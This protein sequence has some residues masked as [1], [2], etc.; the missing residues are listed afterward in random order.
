VSARRR[1][2]GA[3]SL[4]C[5]AVSLAAP[6]GAGAQPGAL[7]FGPC[8]PKQVIS[9]PAGLQCA[10]L[11]V[12][13]DRANPAAG[14]IGLAVQRVP[15]SGP[16][17]GV[18]VLL[19]GGPGQPALPAFEQVVAPLAREHTL[20]GF[21]LVAFDQR[22]T[23]QSQSL[24]CPPEG[25]SADLGLPSPLGRGLSSYLNSCGAALGPTR[26]Y[27]TSQ[28]SVEDLNA[29]REALGGT[30]LSLFAV[31]YGTRVAGM[32]AREYPQGVARMVLDS[33]VPTTGPSP[34]GTERLHALHRVLDEG[35]CGGGACRAFS[36]DVYADLT[37]VVS[38]LHRHPLHTKT[39]NNRGRLRQATIT[40]KSLLS[41]LLGLDLAPLTRVL[42]PAAIAAAAHGHLAPLARIAG[43]MELELGGGGRAA[44]RAVP[45]P[46]SRF[47]PLEG[48]AGAGGHPS[49]ADVSTSAVLDVATSCVEDAL[50]WSP[51]SPPGARA[52]VLRRWLA[53]LPAGT[54]A[55]FSSAAALGESD[56]PLCEGWPA[57]TPAPPSPTGLSATPTL[58]LS[59][60][61]DLRTPY[62][63]VLAN[64]P[65]YSDA[66]LLRVPDDGHSTVT[67]DPTGCAKRA[68]IE[69]L[70]SGRA[71][72]SCPDSSEPQA[73]PLPPGSLAQV[74]PAASRSRLAGRIAAAAAITLEDLLGQDSFAG[75][76]LRGG[77]WELGELG[78]EASGNTFVLH[79]MV[80]VPGV[81][82]S[83]SVHLGET[84]GGALKLSGH[85]TVGGRLP[86][87]L[88]LHDR[89]LTGRIGGARVRARLAA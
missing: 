13:F 89:T 11:D 83:G 31:S 56:L 42:A 8:S 21:E 64:L 34:L 74:A 78:P 73:L 50:P 36:S 9:R 44:G 29:L 26:A 33:L 2:L 63:Q 81:K 52:G 7:A 75:G 4:G 71:P 62:E 51:A 47:G 22:G 84:T 69:F 41:M 45:L 68:M 6:G 48:E 23:G 88:T 25:E 17:T 12:P 18:I 20:A 46:M 10:T 5:A 65:T 80:D 87:R 66:Q 77:S 54:T 38:A 19:A 32:Y 24:Q 1:L 55:P 72:A 59:G 61:D 70:A 14:S 67:T 30:P 43:H 16:R 86:G 40:E 53:S 82:L 58:I 28:E 49:L 76:G 3:L 39:Y 57:T 15:A 35:I 27:Y 60:D 37:R 85:L 79:A